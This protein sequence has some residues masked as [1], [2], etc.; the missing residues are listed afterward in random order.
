M[1]TTSFWFNVTIDMQSALATAKTVTAIQKTSP[2]VVT[3][4]DVNETNG[5]YVLMSTSGMAQINNRVL[6]V[7]NTSASPSEFQAESLDATGFSTFSSGSFQEITFGTQFSTITNVTPSG[8]DPEFDD[9]TLVHSTARTQAVTLTSPFTVVF[10]S[11]WDPSDAALTAAKS[12][13]DSN[14]PKCVRI[15]FAA[16]PRVAFYAD[17]GFAYLPLGTVPGKVT[18]RLTFSGKGLS[19]NWSS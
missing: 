6:R 2:A 17:I 10:D 8:G 14:S 19:S 5:N 13:A 9:T 18:T 3:H 11:L 15:S 16:G 1:T 7:S 4:S 12:A